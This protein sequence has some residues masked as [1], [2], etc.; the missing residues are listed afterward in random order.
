MAK[1]IKI[2]LAHFF[3]KK[4]KDKKAHA[5]VFIQNFFRM[6]IVCRRYLRYR[7]AIIRLQIMFRAYKAKLEPVAESFDNVI[8][9]SKKE[10]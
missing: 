6:V 2:F 1:Q 7:K 8:L 4:M 9:K 3:E 10:W 5:I